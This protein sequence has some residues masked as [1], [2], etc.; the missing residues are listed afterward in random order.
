VKVTQFRD[1]IDQSIFVTFYL[2]NLRK[3]NSCWNSPFVQWTNPLRFF[4]RNEEPFSPIMMRVVGVFWMLMWVTGS[5]PIF[6]MLSQDPLLVFHEMRIEVMGNFSDGYALRLARNSS[7]CDSS[8]N[9]VGGIAAQNIPPTTISNVVRWTKSDSITTW[10]ASFL[11]RYVVESGVVCWSDNGGFTWQTTVTANNDTNF[12]LWKHAPI[13][14]AVPQTVTAGKLFRVI[15]S[16]SLPRFARGVLVANETS[17][18][19][20]TPRGPL[21][22]TARISGSGFEF[23]PTKHADEAFLCVS[24]TFSGPWS[25]VPF[26]TAGS[27]NRSITIFDPS[28]RFRIA[29]VNCTTWISGVR[30]Y[31]TVQVRNK[32]LL[33]ISPANI[34]ISLL[35]DGG[36]VSEC[37]LP[38]LEVIS[39]TMV[40]FSYTPQRGGS[41][42]TISLQFLNNPLLIVSDNETINYFA[43][44]ANVLIR[45][46]T[47]IR[48]VDVIPWYTQD[49]SLKKFYVGPPFSFLQHYQS[50]NLAAYSAFNTTSNWVS[51]N[52]VAQFRGR[53]NLSST[54]D[55]MAITLNTSTQETIVQTIDVPSS[56]QQCRLRIYYYLLAKGGAPEMET[57]VG[58]VKLSLSRTLIASFDLFVFQRQVIVV[59]SDGRRSV[60]DIFAMEQIAAE[61]SISTTPATVELNLTIDHRN[62]QQLFFVGPEVLCATSNTAKTNLQDIRGLHRLFDAVGS[63]STLLKWKTNGQFNGDP[64][65]NQWQ[66]VEC[67]HMRVV[68][69]RLANKSLSGVLPPL[70]E[71]T[72]LE[73]VDF[74]RNQITGGFPLN[75]SRLSRVDVSFNKL[76]SLS[77]SA[78]AFGLSSHKC[79]RYFDA[80]NNQITSFPA[81]SLLP[82]IQMLDLSAN[83][84]RSQ[85]PDFS[86]VSPKLQSLQLSTNHLVGSLPALPATILSLDV[87]ANRFSGSIPQWQLP[88][89]KFI[90]I[91]KN[92]INGTIPWTISQISSG[93]VVFR[94]EDNFLTG[95]VPRLSFKLTD[96]RSNFFQCPLMRPEIDTNTSE[97][98]VIVNWGVNNWCDFNSADAGF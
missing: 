58:S 43:N 19:G 78:G 13:A 12:R 47:S 32:T 81:L 38:P 7:S 29:T 92:E 14:I 94:A 75:N 27:S 4:S 85:L 95:L 46:I 56:S 1:Q 24:L 44:A 66:G 30:S 67:R 45:N 40:G 91:S 5:A 76:S 15:V 87:S 77:T 65:T 62:A 60:G 97:M 18:F 84:M 61:V 53:Q 54:D 93:E 90:D 11:P 57:F 55:L 83:E 64:C 39:S 42:G 9:F 33:S 88:K 51:Q 21:S 35:T 73:T 37:P 72:M 25:V 26:A 48:Q 31:C 50:T 82:Q 41:E 6:S 49:L 74:S 3:W 86:V 71:L 16:P 22:E 59:R 69:L 34:R 63:S 2:S 10:T 20:S 36:G 70:G 52:G 17:C 8:V 89:I 98:N 28:V 79:I 23:H 80:K 68:S 96:V